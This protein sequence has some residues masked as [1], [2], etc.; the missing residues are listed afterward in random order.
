LS[1]NLK[2][3]FTMDEMHRQKTTGSYGCGRGASMLLGMQVVAGCA[4]GEIVPFDHSNMREDYRPL[5]HAKGRVTSITNCDATN[6]F[7]VATQSG[8]LSRHSFNGTCQ[9]VL[10][11]AQHAILALSFPTSHSD[12]FATASADGAISIWDSASSTMTCTRHVQDAGAALCIVTL[13]GSLVVGF[14]DGQLRAFK[15]DAQLTPLWE[16][17]NAHAFPESTGV[18]RLAVSR[19]GRTLVS[20]GV[21]GEVRLWNATSRSLVRSALVAMAFVVCL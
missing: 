17:P 9:E 11:A 3:E 20:A 14:E 5:A 13:E 19:N 12:T 7:Y 4:S 2:R 8:Y 10:K 16:L 18:T 21:G 15:R 1:L 6:H